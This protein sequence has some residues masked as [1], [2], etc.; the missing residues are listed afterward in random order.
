MKKFIV[1]SNNTIENDKVDGKTN[2]PN[3]R[4]KKIYDILNK[5]Y[6]IMIPKNIVNLEEIKELKVH[7]NKYLDFLES[8]Y[9]AFR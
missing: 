5:K 8:A 6:D 4:H 2:K 3:I 7:D 9:K 1:I